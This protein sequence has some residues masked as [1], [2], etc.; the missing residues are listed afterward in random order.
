MK[1]LPVATND[2]SRQTYLTTEEA[3]VYTRRASAKAFHE[4]ARTHGLPKCRMGRAV[5]YRR[6]DLDRELQ[7]S[8]S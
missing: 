4:F 2:L 3:A 1:A 6:A 8:A 7:R 5:L